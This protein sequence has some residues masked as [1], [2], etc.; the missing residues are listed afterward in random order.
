MPG[1]EKDEEPLLLNPFFEDPEPELTFDE[2]GQ[3]EGVTE[4]GRITVDV[5]GLDRELLRRERER[6]ARGIWREFTDFTQGGI[7]EDVFQKKMEDACDPSARFAG[8]ARCLYGKLL[9]AYLN[10]VDDV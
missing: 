5:C 4:R 9:D 10:Q 8:M 2:N 7:R 1:C 6:E 3:I